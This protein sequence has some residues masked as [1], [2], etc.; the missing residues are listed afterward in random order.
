MRLLPMGVWGGVRVRVL[1]MELWH[2]RCRMS[3]RLCVPESLWR[4]G[5]CV[6][7]LVWGALGGVSARRVAV[8]SI[9]EQVQDA[10][11]LLTGRCPAWKVRFVLPCGGAVIR[12]RVQAAAQ[13]LTGRYLVVVVRWVSGGSWDDGA[14]MLAG[15]YAWSLRG[16][17]TKRRTLRLLSELKCVAGARARMPSKREHCV[18]NMNQSNVLSLRG[19]CE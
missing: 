13:P 19:P 7:V 15:T 4:W 2:E 12:E 8:V 10:A 14:V 5:K 17:C 9:R 6:R 11:Q 16:R 18:T 3:V 1:L